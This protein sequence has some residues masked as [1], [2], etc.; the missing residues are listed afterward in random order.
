MLLK[1]TFNFNPKEALL[2]LYVVCV[3]MVNENVTLLDSSQTF[4]MQTR[5]RCV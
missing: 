4:E 1:W 3:P 2:T 5:A